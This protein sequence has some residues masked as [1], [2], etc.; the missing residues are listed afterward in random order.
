METNAIINQV[1]VWVAS[2]G[3]GAVVVRY[4]SK[5]IFAI[6]NLASRKVPLKLTES[7]RKQ[8]ALEA[9][10]ETTKLLAMGIKVDVD[11]QI[12]KATNHQ[13]ELLKEQN[14]EYIRQNNKLVALMRKMGLV[15]ADLKSPS[16]TFRDD[17]RHEID[18]DFTSDAPVQSL[19]GDPVRA[20]IEVSDG[21]TIP[22]KTNKKSKEKY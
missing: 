21:V 8:I 19:I 18:T 17:L 15:V 3:G 12:D 14:R 9:A 22:G 6:I 7:D 16:S 10:T 1:M 11:G 20:T 2:I 5:I 4:L 13:I